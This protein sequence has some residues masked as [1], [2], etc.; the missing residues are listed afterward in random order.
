[1]AKVIV[2]P[3]DGSV[4][5]SSVLPHLHKA[6]QHRVNEAHVCAAPKTIAFLPTL[7]LPQHMCSVLRDSDIAVNCF[8][9]DI[10]FFIVSKIFLGPEA[11]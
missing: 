11:M 2:V 7:N 8:P 5:R 4:A 3:R 6:Q 9:Y 10:V 1:M